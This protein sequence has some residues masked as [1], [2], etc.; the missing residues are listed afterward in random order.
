MSDLSAKELKQRWIANAERLDKKGH[1]AKYLPEQREKV[2]RRGYLGIWRPD[3]AIRIARKAAEMG[4]AFRTP[5]FNDDLRD[6]GLVGEEA[7]ERLLEILAEVPPELYEPPYE[8]EE[9]PGTP[10]IFHCGVL[11]GEVYFK[12]QIKGTQRK[13]QVVFWSCHPPRLNRK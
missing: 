9:P 6:F 11:A 7:R 10:F 3:E 2:L 4:V 5:N 1:F 8:L 13:P 12:F